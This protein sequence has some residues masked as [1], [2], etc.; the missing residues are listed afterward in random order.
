MPT[1]PPSAVKM[2]PVTPCAPS[3]SSTVRASRSSSKP[4]SVNVTDVSSEVSYASLRTTGASLTASTV[5]LTVSTALS[6]SP[7]LTMKSNES[8]PL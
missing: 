3:H 4:V 5:M 8:S 1:A 7:S 2:V 6:S